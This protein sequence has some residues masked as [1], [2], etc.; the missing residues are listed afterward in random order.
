MYTST[1]GL[2]QRV[3]SDVIKYV[4]RIDK[5]AAQLMVDLSYQFP[6]DF[7]FLCLNVDYADMKIPQRLNHLV[8]I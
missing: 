7:P 8:K 3:P 6:I 5:P 1:D 2:E 4:S